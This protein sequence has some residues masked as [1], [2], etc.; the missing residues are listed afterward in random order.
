MRRSLIHFRWINLAVLLGAG[1]ATAVLT[2]ALLVGDSVRG[3]LRDLALE[4]LGR[5]DHAL[6]AARFFR[7]GLIR[8]L[9]AAPEFANSFAAAVPVILL[10]GSAAHG[11]TR[12]RA[13]RVQVQGIDPSFADLFVPEYSELVDGLARK[14]GQLFPPLVVNQAL[15]RELGAALG[16]PVLLSFEQPQALNPEFVFGSRQSGAG[17]RTLRFTLARV[18]PDRG[19]GR[20][21]LQPHQALPLNAFVPL[22]VLQ[23]ALAQQGRANAVLVAGRD[24]GSGASAQIL[25]DVLR[26]VWKMDDLGLM[27]KAAP[28][29]FALESAAFVLP[30]DVV[31]SAVDLAAASGLQAQPILTY[32]ANTTEA[33]ER[34][35]P[36]STVSAFDP[37]PGLPPLELED[38]TV[39]PVLAAGEILLNQWAA[40]DLG[41]ALGDEISLSYFV[42]G[43][44]GKL[45]TQRA[46][47]RLRGVVALRGLGADPGLTPVFPGMQ[48]ADDMAA[49]EA[50]FPVDLALIGPRDEAYWDQFEAAPKGF[51]AHATGQRLWRSR[52][53]QT[54]ALRF[55]PAPG[56][57]ARQASIQFG[58]QLLQKIP[59][60]QVG[61]AFQPVRARALEAAAGA[62]DFSMLFIGF[63]LFLIVAAALMVGLLFRLGVEQR[64]G[65][66]GVL[67][68][69]G[70]PLAAV[71]RRFLL[72]G[73][74]LAAAGGLLGLGGAASYAWLLLAGLRTWW[75]AA[76]GTPF[77]VLHLNPWSLALGWGVS[78]LVV[79]FALGRTL[80]QC[81]RI[82]LRTL[83]AGGAIQGEKKS[84]GRARTLAFASLGL[85]LLALPVALLADPVVALGLFF[86]SGALLLVG[87]LACFSLWLRGGRRQS[88]AAGPLAR[89][90]LGLWNSARHPGRSLLCAAL[91]GCACFVI[92]AVGANRRVEAG[93]GAALDKE[94]GTGGFPLLATADI[95]LHQDLNEPEGRF[96]LGFA[97]SENAILDRAE[98]VPFRVLPGEDVSCLNLYQPQQPGLLGV[99]DELIQRGGFRFQQTAAATPEE[100]ANPWLLLQRELEPGVIP[101]L[102]DYNS[103]LWILHLGLGDEL[104]LRNEAGEDL[105]L[106]LVGL[107]KGSLF[108]S[109]LLISESH[110]KRHFPT[111]SGYGYFL[112]N[113]PPAG[114]ESVAGALEETLGVFGFDV[115]STSARLEA[116][117]AVE[118]TYLSTFQTLGGLGLLLGTVGLGIVLWRNAVERRG[119]LATLRA[120]GFRVSTLGAM[121]LVE[122]G[123]LLL[124]GIVA[125]SAAALVA[126]APHLATP[127]A[128]VPWL[129]LLGILGLVFLVGVGA[130]AAAA[131][132]ALRTPLLPALKAE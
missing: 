72:Q 15:Q 101:A 97:A 14:P 62:T 50:P 122:N 81:G 24:A 43:R 64:A 49:W 25:R 113:T 13:S 79:L 78:L 42:V 38:G 41:V 119:E 18:L 82:P 116:Y 48:E 128:A 61:L 46:L 3:S 92:V 23:K 96:E 84:A 1:V 69:T 103:V 112:V 104:V 58:A 74:V 68:A 132:W 89:A 65:E 75:L 83:L 94:S 21:G 66:I 59:P 118:N 129:Q 93:S 6:V 9:E 80:G 29:Y 73:L 57:D 124:V 37:V 88:L 2:G 28:D 7:L 125:G 5:I 36:Y 30:Q 98:I 114:L 117:R 107:L 108:Q 87:G 115:T 131:L 109:E 106:R 121:L 86:A 95:P 32:L 111:R 126:V 20:F 27:L 91:V 105:R 100:R 67:L 54:T 47:F 127:G 4:R 56:Q 39:A 33:G 44:R 70:Y 22:A 12:A 16:D 52:F 8:D 120:C 102:G 45:S 85:G 11:A 51:V 60:A 31:R 90:R 123:F 63:S 71:R 26:R 34:L 99:P 76:V 10:R 130:S 53:G 40:A 55:G 19:P 77:L 35:L 110:F 17:V